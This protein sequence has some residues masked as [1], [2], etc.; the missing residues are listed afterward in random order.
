MMVVV[1][2]ER[3]MMMVMVMRMRE[4]SEVGRVLWFLGLMML[5]LHPPG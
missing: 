1:M 5:V 3:M 4:G 2:E